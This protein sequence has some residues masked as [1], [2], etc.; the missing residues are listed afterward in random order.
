MLKIKHISFKWHLSLRFT[1]PRTLYHN[2]KQQQHS[3]QV[4]ELPGYAPSPTI[5]LWYLFVYDSA[6]VDDGTIISLFLTHH[7]FIIKRLPNII[8]ISFTFRPVYTVQLKHHQHI[9]INHQNNCI[10]YITYSV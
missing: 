9:R 8:F 5:H 1:D 4:Y 3:D 10:Q 2:H 6:F 7:K